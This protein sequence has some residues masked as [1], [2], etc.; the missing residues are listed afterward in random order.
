MRQ[1][2]KVLDLIVSRLP[3]VMGLK[4]CTIRLIDST[5]G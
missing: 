3:E 2:D 1:L 5:K 4:A